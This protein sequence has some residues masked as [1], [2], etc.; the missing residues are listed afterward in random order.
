MKVGFEV[1]LLEEADTIVTLLT[2]V[3]HVAHNGVA[4][5]IVDIL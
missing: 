4:R 2:A 1:R 5:V 3:S